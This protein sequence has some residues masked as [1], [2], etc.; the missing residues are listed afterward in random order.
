MSGDLDRSIATFKALIDF[1]PNPEA[2]F[3]LALA[4]GEKGDLAEEARY[5]ERYL[6][7][8]KGESEARV[9]QARQELERVKARMR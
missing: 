8:P 7:D 3:N 6:D 1:A 9:R 5:L 4:C 2:Y